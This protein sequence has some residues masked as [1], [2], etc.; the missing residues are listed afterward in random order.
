VEESV[1]GYNTVMA[2][3]TAEVWSLCEAGDGQRFDF[4]LAQIVRAKLAANERRY[5]VKVARGSNRMAP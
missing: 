2:D 5:P 1:P 3:L 4:D